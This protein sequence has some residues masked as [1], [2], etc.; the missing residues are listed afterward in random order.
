LIRSLR[1]RAPAALAQINAHGTPTFTLTHAAFIPDG[2]AW[3]VVQR[4]Y[5]VS[6][7]FNCVQAI[8]A[9]L[10]VEGGTVITYANRTSTDQVAGFG[11]GT[12]RSIGSK[13]L[14]SQ[15]EALFKK[16][17]AAAKK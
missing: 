7:G 4:M 10:P 15:L 16:A 17:Q 12:K 2:N 1:H 14:E 13:L 9:L 3:V 6:T 11:G 8:A 5:Y